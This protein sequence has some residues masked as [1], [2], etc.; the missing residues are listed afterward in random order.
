MV[1][2]LSVL[3]HKA[4]LMLGKGLGGL[5]WFIDRGHRKVA[6]DNLLR[7]LPDLNPRERG[8]IVIEVYKNLGLSLAEWG[9]NQG[10]SR[11]A[12][13]RRV[14]FEGFE[15]ADRGLAKG[16]GVLIV[17][18]H[19]GNWE[20]TGAVVAARL[21]ETVTV[22]AQAQNN[23]RFD[24]YINAL[25]SKA[26]MKVILAESGAAQKMISTLGHNKILGILA[27]QNAGAKGLMLN[28]FGR[29]CS[30][31]RS[32]VL[33][34]RRAGATMVCAG[35]VRK[36]GGKHVLRMSPPVDLGGTLAEATSRWLMVFENWIREDPGQWFWV[37]RRWKEDPN[38][39]NEV[40]L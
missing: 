17:V 9:H 24:Q 6:N 37:H 18:A 38:E 10:L 14:A 32:P 22:A 12:L 13:L 21:P 25:R 5:V 40:S 1:W 33:L 39:K 36:P 3:P 19:L 2:L 7:A 31:L 27:D 30:V 35:L 28:F 16:K 20:M 4:A 15:H 26:G 29:P 11:E 8:R 23:K 34:A